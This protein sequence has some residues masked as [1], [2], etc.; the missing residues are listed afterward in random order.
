MKLDLHSGSQLK[1]AEA[2]W[3]AYYE[4]R[5]RL[6]GA[7]AT[8]APFGDPLH[9]KPDASTFTSVGD[10]QVV[11][12]PTGGTLDTWDTP[13]DLRQDS[14][15]QGIIPILK[16]NGTDEWIETPDASFWNNTADGTGPN[17]PSYTWTV[18]A[19]IV[20]GSSSQALFS[21]TSA[22]GTSG[23][24]WITYVRSN[25]SVAAISIDDSA[26]ASIGRATGAQTVGVWLHLVITKAT[27]VT[28]GAFV[29]YVNGAAADNGNTGSG[30]YTAQED[31]IT[32]VRIGA[33]SDGGAPLV[34]TLAGGPLG[35]LF[36]PGTVL[37]TDAILRD[38]EL[39]R[40]ALAL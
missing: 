19:K 5:L 12:T 22:I 1:M 23:T 18:W 2:M 34:S 27:G 7:T 35:P 13:M 9:G 15:W 38:Y 3:P 33:E 25:E 30:S 36:L 10:E 21:K 40:R 29:V 16:F 37:S 26:G 6:A 11:W 32:V 39:G 20:A 8:I 4:A 28:N 24:D 14:S 31:G 17:E